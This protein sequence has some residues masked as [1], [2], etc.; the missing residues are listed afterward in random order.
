MQV[1]DAEILHPFIDLLMPCEY[2]SNHCLFE[3]TR[4]VNSALHIARNIARSKIS[5]MEG[6]D[7]P[8]EGCLPNVHVNGRKG[9]L[10]ASLQHKSEGCHVGS[11]AMELNRSW[12]RHETQ[13]TQQIKSNKHAKR[14]IACVA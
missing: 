6:H 8:Q 7:S 5:T 4:D 10:V 2:D 9:L 14:T 12:E 1:T 11:R 3:V 13:L